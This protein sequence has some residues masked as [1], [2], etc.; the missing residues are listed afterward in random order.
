MLFEKDL[1]FIEGDEIE[2]FENIDWL[3]S[4]TTIFA[5]TSSFLELHA[6]TAL[7][8]KLLP[9]LQS[10]NKKL[11]ISTRTIDYLNAHRALNRPDISSALDILQTLRN[12]GVLMDAKDPHVISGDPYET[13]N[14]FKEL[15]V[16]FQF[17]SPLTLLTQNQD[18]AFQV[19]KNARSEAFTRA[20]LV[21]VG[22]LDRGNIANWIPKIKKSSEGQGTQPLNSERLELRISR[23]FKIISDTCSLMLPNRKESGFRGKVFFQNVLFPLLQG[24]NNQL[25]V[26]M[27]VIRELEKHSG[28]VQ[29]PD[30]SACAQAGL[31]AIEFYD[32]ANLVIRAEDKHEVLGAGSNFADPVFLKVV[33]GYQAEFNI[34]VITQDTNLAR[35]ILDNRNPGKYELLVLY[36]DEYSK[37][38]QLKNWIERLAEKTRKE[39]QEARNSNMPASRGEPRNNNS[40]APP[41]QANTGGRQDDAHMRQ[42]EPVKSRGDQCGKMAAAQVPSSPATVAPSRRTQENPPKQQAEAFPLVQHPV[43]INETLLTV[44]ELPREKV[45]VIGR[46]S[47]P[48]TLTKNLATG[49]EGTIYETN[50][51]GQVCKIYHENCLTQFRRDKLE[52][53]VTRNINIKGVC[54]PTELVFSK[55]DEFLGFMM[56]KVEGQM[57]KTSVFAKPLLEK[58]FPHWNKAHLVQLALTVLRLLEQLHNI[59][60]F[61][62][63][64][65]P[66]NILIKDE[67][68][69]SFV[70][71]DSFQVAGFPCPVG[72]ETFT[73]PGRQGHEYK[74]FL[75]T[76]DDE[77]FAVTTLLFMIL[78]PGKTPYSSQGGGEMAENIRNHR[79]PYGRDAEG[80]PPVG[81]WQFIWSHL[82]P[83]LKTDFSDVF[84]LDRRVP[85]TAF[86]EHLIVFRND[87]KEGRRDG[88]IFPAEPLMREGDKVQVKCISCPAGAPE[89]NIT[90]THAERLSQEGR[91]FKC[92][93]CIDLQKLTRIEET[94]IVTCASKIST[95]CMGEVAVP[96]TYLHMLQSKGQSYWCKACSAEKRK[97]QTRSSQC[98]VATAAFQSQS[99][100]E[101]VFLRSYRDLIL[102]KT[103]VGR[104]LIA[105]Y[106]RVGPDLASVIETFPGTRNWSK[107]FI[108]FLIKKIKVKY[109]NIALIKEE[110]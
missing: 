107:L 18:L 79:F 62:G 64:I 103:T 63:D 46:L 7:V 86:M 10:F 61:V 97:A 88:T 11:W 72:V 94:K 28:D 91:P 45:T 8:D 100:P 65:N 19:A 68:N 29:N 59:N 33:I 99:A 9:K 70:D 71:V 41:S 30:K 67:L 13:Q 98:F 43:K 106:Y 101:V 76:K 104:G 84:S 53:M 36:I 34:C 20:A 24:A 77:L 90:K 21:V 2:I 16:G 47:G 60:I 56:P 51:E 49:G 75:R 38:P 95:N 40:A 26:P 52:L 89:H 83:R 44:R 12:Q 81:A 17:K 37:N 55:H 54:W 78:F 108:N 35:T 73:P 105:L 1:P 5:D 50:L 42:T 48:L 109:P 92:T 14:L 66:Q 32:A 96:L 31:D 15:F 4:E 27:R 58:K 3:T 39:E 23:D 85:I 82:H 57:M 69:V 22:Y 6:K 25:L 102:R 87:I 74:D 110:P 80:R 93:P